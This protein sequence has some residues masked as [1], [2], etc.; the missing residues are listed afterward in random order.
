MTILEVLGQSLW[1]AKHQVLHSSADAV[2]APHDL[3]R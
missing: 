2:Y 1:D 3:G